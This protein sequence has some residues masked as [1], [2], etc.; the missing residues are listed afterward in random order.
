MQFKFCYILIW[1]RILPKVIAELKLPTFIAS[2]MVLQREPMRSRLWGWAA[3]MANVTVSLDAGIL[4]F[5]N[6]DWTGSWS[7]ELPPQAAGVGH[8]ITI[9]D[10]SSAISLEDIA[11]GDV[12]LCSG[13]SNM[14]FTSNCGV[15]AVVFWTVAKRRFG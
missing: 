3:P 11:F 9:S 5:S 12:Y 10:G 7:A 13:Q 6:A 4:V 14:D 15:S 1:L 8:T 2:H